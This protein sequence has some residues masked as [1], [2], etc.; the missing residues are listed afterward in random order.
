LEE[1]SARKEAFE[2]ELVDIRD[3]LDRFAL[4]LPSIPKRMEDI[5]INMQ[6]KAFGVLEAMLDLVGQQLAYLEKFGSSH[7][8]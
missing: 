2:E 6:V 7:I 1:D 5:E 8:Q 3:E 4:I